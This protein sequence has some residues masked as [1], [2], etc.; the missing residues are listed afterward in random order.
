MDHSPAVLPFSGWCVKQCHDAP[1]PRNCRIA[2]FVNGTGL[3]IAA[4]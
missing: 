2:A 1:A 3:H 4:L